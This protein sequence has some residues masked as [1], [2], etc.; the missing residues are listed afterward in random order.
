MFHVKP[1]HGNVSL[2][3]TAQKTAMTVYEQ[4]PARLNDS[5][6]QLVVINR[7]RLCP[8][9]DGWLAHCDASYDCPLTTCYKPAR[10]LLPLSMFSLRT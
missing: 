9:R 3:L 8:S 7:V 5:V 4:I 2:A 6:A 1:S 10:R